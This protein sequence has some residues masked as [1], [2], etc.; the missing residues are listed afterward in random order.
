MIRDEADQDAGAELTGG[1]PTSA[2]VGEC[3]S[4]RELAVVRDELLNGGED[5]VGLG[6]NYVFQQRLVGDEGIFGGEA[7]HRRIEF[8]E[9]FAADA[10]RDFSAISPAQ[11]VFVN[12]QHAAGLAD[13][14]GDGLEVVG[15][16]GA[17][18][19]HLDADSMLALQPLRGLQRRAERWRRR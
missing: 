8:V 16:Q 19:E 11:H 7:L 4:S 1:W 14:G 15:V 2:S 13:R 17:Q 3:G 10:G 6:Q 12:D 18:I 5:V 9:E